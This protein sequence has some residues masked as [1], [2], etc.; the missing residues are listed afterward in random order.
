[1]CSNHDL[2]ALPAEVLGWQ[3]GWRLSVLQG[4][5]SLTLYTRCSS[6]HHT[7]SA[8][9]CNCR[10][11]HRHAHLLKVCTGTCKP[12]LPMRGHRAL[13]QGR[14]AAGRCSMLLGRRGGAL[15]LRKLSIQSSGKQHMAAPSTSQSPSRSRMCH[16]MRSLIQANRLLACLCHAPGSARATHALRCANLHVSVFHSRLLSEAGLMAG[17][18]APA[19][20]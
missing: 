15:L 2:G 3:P 9:L 11:D 20:V 17:A 13:L 18:V 12:S 16:N 1:M 4:K 14:W 19:G 7:Q 10:C 8:A 5:L 6:G